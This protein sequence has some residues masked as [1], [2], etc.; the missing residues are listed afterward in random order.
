[1]ANGNGYDQSGNIRP[2]FMP[3]Y[4]DSGVHGAERRN[5][6]LGGNFGQ[7]SPTYFEHPSWQAR[8]AAS[9]GQGF[10]NEMS[11]VDMQLGNFTRLNEY[12]KDLEARY[13]NFG[14]GDRPPKPSGFGFNMGTLGAVGDIFGGAGSFMTGMGALET[15][16]YAGKSF[17][18]KSKY[19]AL[20]WGEQLKKREGDVLEANAGIMDDNAYRTAQGMTNLADLIRA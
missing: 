19:N 2:G 20:N 11:G 6:G 16:K 14:K 5:M 13:K 8:K 17:D 1:M 7:A 9:Q 3:T 10:G 12:I 15:A 18:E 4:S